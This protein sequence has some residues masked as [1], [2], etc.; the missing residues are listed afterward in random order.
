MKFPE[1][2]IQLPGSDIQFVG[3]PAPKKKMSWLTESNKK[4]RILINSEDWTMNTLQHAHLP[5]KFGY[6]MIQAWL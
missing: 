4:P 1:I 5:H 2:F 3:F 6:N